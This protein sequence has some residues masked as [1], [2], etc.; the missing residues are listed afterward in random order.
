MNGATFVARI[1]HALAARPLN[2]FRPK[3]LAA[4]V[5]CSEDTAR[6]TLKRLTRTGDVV[7]DGYAAYRWARRPAHVECSCHAE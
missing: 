2:T 6:Q 5:E 4:L 7:H 1:R 3:Q